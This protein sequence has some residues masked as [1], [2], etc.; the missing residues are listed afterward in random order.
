MSQY[1][2]FEIGTFGVGTPFIVS[3]VL[4]RGD[5]K[6]INSGFLLKASRSSDL[7]VSKISGNLGGWQR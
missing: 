6:R 7:P 5:E 4:A 3:G 1:L 2:A